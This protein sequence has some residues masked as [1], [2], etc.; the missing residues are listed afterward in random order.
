MRQ[1]SKFDLFGFSREY[2][3]ELQA[4]SKLCKHVA[5]SVNPKINARSKTNCKRITIKG[6][7]S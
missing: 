1:Q 3:R 4:L 5:V 2:F 6:I 7:I